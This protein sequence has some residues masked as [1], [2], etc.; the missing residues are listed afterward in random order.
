[1]WHKRFFYKKHLQKKFEAEK[2]R[3]DKELLAN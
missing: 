1:M 3:K 2:W